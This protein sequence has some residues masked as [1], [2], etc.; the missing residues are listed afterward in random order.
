MLKNVMGIIDLDRADGSMFKDLAEYRTLGSI[1]FGGRY[2]LIDFVLSNMVNSGI[3]NIGILLTEKSRS[4]MDHLRSGKDWDLAK[5]RGGLSFLPAVQ[6]FDQLVQGDVEGLFRN[7]DFIEHSTDKYV[8]LAGIGSVYNMDLTPM[9]MF[10]ENTGADITIVY[11]KV[12]ANPVGEHLIL[13]LAENGLAEDVVMKNGCADGELESVG[14]MLMETELFCKMLRNAFEHGSKDFL[15][16]AFLRNLDKYTVYGYEHK[17]YVAR[18]NSVAT[19][20]Q[21]SMDLLKPDVLNELFLQ[22]NPIYTKTKD[23]VPVQYKNGSSVKN[24]MIA[25]GCII[26]GDVENC[27]LFRGVHVAKGAKLSNS[28]VMQ[29]CVIEPGAQLDYAICDKNVKVT[30]GKQ[31]KG[32]ERYPFV[33]GKNIVI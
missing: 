20:F 28:I 1:P 7:I 33:V 17:G 26:E 24:S 11:N 6:R 3:D 8:L 2:R 18:M 14:M 9:L 22:S 10:H 13:K 16:D 25:N 31:L 19:Y 29:K 27:I 23:E 12:K 30:E 21:A 5:H 15:K 4:I 32:D